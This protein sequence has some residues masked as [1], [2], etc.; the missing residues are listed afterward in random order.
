VALSGG[1]PALLQSLG[2][3]HGRLR[4]PEGRLVHRFS[5]LPV[6]RSLVLHTSGDSYAISPRDA[7]AF[8]QELEQRRRLGAIQQLASGVEV[9][10]MFFYAFWDDRVVRWALLGAFVLNLALLGWLMTIYPSLPNPLDLRIADA[11]GEVVTLRPRHQILFL[12]LAAFV[13]SL[14]N[15]GLGLM[16]YRREPAGARLLQLG[17]L[18]V[19]LLFGVAI[20][21]IV[22]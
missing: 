14:L 1:L 6:R 17:S 16:L 20:L 8:V 2:Y 22:R 9:G 21:S 11:A 18:L 10:R 19:Q 4:L 12:P 7:D 15:I 3:Y 13:L 5:S